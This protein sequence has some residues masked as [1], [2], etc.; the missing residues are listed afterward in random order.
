MKYNMD[1]KALARVLIA[2][3]IFMLLSLVVIADADLSDRLLEIGDQGNQPSCAAWAVTYA[4][5]MMWGKRFSPAYIYNLRD[6]YQRTCDE[7]KGM[8]VGNAMR[9]AKDGCALWN[10]FLYDDQD[11]CTL[12]TLTTQYKT[13]EAT[14]L[15]GRQGDADLDELKSWLDSGF[16]II[17]TIPLFM[18][19]YACRCGYAMNGPKHWYSNPH[20][21][22][23]V[24]IVGYDNL[25]F[26]FAN[27]QGTDWACEGYGWIT[28]NFM[29]EYAFEGW[30][31]MENYP[32]TTVIPLV[33]GE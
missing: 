22:H 10:E 2:I 24:L 3:T 16:P 15:F 18:D 28:E 8:A 11:P 6:L 13:K 21:W 31:M 33:M 7:D 29:Q 4:K 1:M 5:G 25:G 9:L 14:I 19:Y 32:Y 27:S 26:K 17:T 23:V 12:P 30:V 20:S